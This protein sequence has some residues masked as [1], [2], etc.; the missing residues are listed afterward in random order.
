MRKLI[1]AA[2]AGA[3]LSICLLAGCS[4]GDD[5][6][7]K[8]VF[9]AGQDPSG[10]TAALIDEYNASHPGIEV[11][12]QVMPANTDTQHDAYVTYFSARESRI[13]L[14]SLDVIWT[15]EFARAGWIRPIPDGL[16]DESE[17]LSGPL[18]SV[19]YEGAIYAV[20]W[21]TDAGVLYYRSDLLEKAGLTVPETWSEFTRACRT[22][23]EP[24]GITGFIWQGAKYEGLVCNFLEFLWSRGGDISPETLRDSPE[25]AVRDVESTI[26]FMLQLIETGISPASVLTYKEEES[27]RLF[28][29]GQ[30]LFLRNWPYVWSIAEDEESSVAGAVGIAPLPHAEG[31]NGYSTIGGWNIAV[32]TYTRYPEEALEF[33]AFI[34]GERSLN[35]RAIDGGYLPTRKSTYGDTDVLA[36]NPHYAGF[37][38]VFQNTRNRPRTP[39]YPIASDIIQENVHRALT[40]EFDSHAAAE[41]IVTEMAA[42]LSR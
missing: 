7:I 5:G 19:T 20:P 39:H 21:F 9:A 42:I 14:Y 6:L 37:F 11:T 30:A 12:F 18:E 32:S 29:E 2:A 22:V 34:T 8:I 10:A 26:D 16:F 25:R 41:S 27:R 13:D 31:E 23:A 40:G 38:D 17:F 36:A 28:T 1:A 15:A 35:L 3:V 24:A 33:L 4:T